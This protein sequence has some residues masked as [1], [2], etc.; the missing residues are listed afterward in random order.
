MVWCACGFMFRIAETE[1]YCHTV[2]FTFTDLYSFV[3]DVQ[4]GVCG[5][6]HHPANGNLLSLHWGHLQ[7]LLL[8]VTERVRLRLECQAHVLPSSRRQ[9]D[10]GVI[11]RH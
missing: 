8:Q 7:R 4:H 10:V 9:L 11:G 1:I 3:A 2:G 6:L 5:P